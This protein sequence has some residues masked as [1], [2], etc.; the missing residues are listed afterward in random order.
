MNS[1]KIWSEELLAAALAMQGHAIVIE[2]WV[3]VMRDHNVDLHFVSDG[4]QYEHVLL[5]NI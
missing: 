5:R 4:S 1:I 3:D 2:G